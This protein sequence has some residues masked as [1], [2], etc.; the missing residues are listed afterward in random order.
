[1]TLWLSSAFSSTVLA[2]LTIIMCA[3]SHVTSENEREEP[4]KYTIDELISTQFEHKDS[5]DLGMD[6]CKAG[7]F[8]LIYSILNCEKSIFNFYS[9]YF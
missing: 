6:P 7:K 9:F 8:L 3:T 4:H 1:M 5:N 2:L